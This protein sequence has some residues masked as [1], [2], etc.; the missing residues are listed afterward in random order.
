MT[1]SS[2]TI[3]ITGAASGIGAATARLLA[4][5]GINLA[6]TA[7]GSDAA[8]RAR[9]AGVAQACAAPGAETCVV[10]ADLAEEGSAAAVVAAALE[11]F[12]ALDA[13]VSNAGFARRGGTLETDR[14]A[15]T[16]SFDVIVAAFLGLLQAGAASLRASPAGSVVAVSSF[17]AHR[18]AADGLF[19]ASAAAKAG[20]E[21]LVRS[22]AAEFAASG[23]TV[24]AVAPGF[25][26]KDADRHSAMPAGAWEQARRRVPLGRL[27]EPRDIAGVI[28]F[29]LGPDARYVTG[30]VIAVDGGLTLG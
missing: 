26:A 13:I 24:N 27:A 4:R 6:L 30:Q 12:G 1:Q 29:L 8:A 23:V 16:H 3:L 17:V 18:F 11:R 5:P 7:R 15:L 2:R 10:E 22:A 14:A 20:L 19:A 28:A 25:T 9:L 21:A